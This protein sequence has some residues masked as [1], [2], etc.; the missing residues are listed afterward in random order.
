MKKV[1]KIFK[2]GRTT[3]WVT[4]L[5]PID[6]ATEKIIMKKMNWYLSLGYSVEKIND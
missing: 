5:L 1:F 2:T 6:Q 3:D 4:I